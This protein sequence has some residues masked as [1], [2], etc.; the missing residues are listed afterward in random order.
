MVRNFGIV[1]HVDHG[2]STLADRLLELT[3]VVNKSDH[4]NQLLD[5]LQVITYLFHRNLPKICELISYWGLCLWSF[6]FVFTSLCWIGNHC[7]RA[8]SVLGGA[9]SWHN[10]ES[11]N[12]FH[13]SWGTV[14][15]FSEM[16]QLCFFARE[17]EHSQ[18]WRRNA[19]NSS[20][21]KFHL[22]LPITSC[23]K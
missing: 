1:A 6:S 7:N 23:G 8:R 19:I 2:K 5:K 14:S 16:N 4:A 9:W 20:S 21:V 12:V 18:E 11:T 15:T 22:L 17:C 13:V 3:G 10:G